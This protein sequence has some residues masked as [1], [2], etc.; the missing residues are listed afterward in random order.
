MICCVCGEIGGDFFPA[1]VSCMSMLL[2]GKLVN[3]CWSVCTTVVSFC[4][5]RGIFL[6]SS[7]RG[8]CGFPKKFYKVGGVVVIGSILHRIVLLDDLHV[9][10]CLNKEPVIV[11]VVYWNVSGVCKI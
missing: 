5:L 2:C 11:I 9:R 6:G 1:C 3:F 10:V 7:P 8:S 4:L